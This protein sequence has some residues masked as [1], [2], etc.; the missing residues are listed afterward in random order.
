VLRRVLRRAGGVDVAGEREHDTD[1]HRG[2]SLAIRAQ[3]QQVQGADGHAHPEALC[4]AAGLGRHRCR[5]APLRAEGAKG[6]RREPGPAGGRGG[7]GVAVHD[8]PCARR[9][10]EAPPL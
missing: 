2:S 7:A 10:E 3:D 4:A 8:A 6:P 5:P 1:G 9:V